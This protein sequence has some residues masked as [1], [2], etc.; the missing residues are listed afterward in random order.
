M[1]KLWIVRH[2]P[3]DEDSRLS[4]DGHKLIRNLAKSI[5]KETLGKT[6]GLI[7][8]NAPRAID[9]AMVLSHRLWAEFEARRELWCDTAHRW[10][11]D[12][13]VALINAEFAEVDVGIVVTHLEYT[14][15]LP[16]AFAKDFEGVSRRGGTQ[17]RGLA[18]RLRKPKRRE[19]RSKPVKQIQKGRASTM[20]IMEN[21]QLPLVS[22]CGALLIEEQQTRLVAQSYR[23]SFWIPVSSKS[24]KS[25]IFLR[26]VFWS[27]V[28]WSARLL[29]LTVPKD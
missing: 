29:P 25:K 7:S 11:V 26:R 10:D 23:A 17:R 1:E 5:S 8:S 9:S 14:E 2:G 22:T 24:T 6:V 12:R 13:A 18:H 21:A 4:E 16:M 3:T 20:L 28:T 15:F 27:S 19:D